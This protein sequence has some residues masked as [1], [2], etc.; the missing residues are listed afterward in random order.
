MKGCPKCHTTRFGNFCHKCGEGLVEEGW[1]EQGVKTEIECKQKNPH[2]IICINP[3]CSTKIIDD[4][5][6]CPI[7][8]VDLRVAQIT[9]V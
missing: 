3:E 8:G 1:K 7:C 6:F 2:F 4:C 9:R 5:K